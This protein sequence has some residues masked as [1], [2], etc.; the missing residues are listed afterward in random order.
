MVDMTKN[1]ANI[2][3]ANIFSSTEEVM[4]TL[5]EEG[6]AG[7][8]HVKTMCSLA[9]MG[10]FCYHKYI[11]HGTQHSIAPMA[12]LLIRSC[13]PFLFPQLKRTMKDRRFSEIEDDWVEWII[14]DCPCLLQ[15]NYQKKEEEEKGKKKKDKNSILC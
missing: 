6:T 4:P 10:W 13:D 1:K 14:I 15:N 5:T 2:A 3:E 7:Q 12:T 11:C 8:I 9:L